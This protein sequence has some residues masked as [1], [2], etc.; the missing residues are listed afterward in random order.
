MSPKQAVRKTNGRKLSG[1]W[2]RRSALQFSASSLQASLTGRGP[3]GASLFQKSLPRWGALSARRLAVAGCGFCPI[4]WAS[5]G[6]EGPP[7][8]GPHPE[9]CA[10]SSPR[11]PV[12]SSPG[13]AGHPARGSGGP[14]QEPGARRP[15]SGRSPSLPQQKPWGH[16]CGCQP[17]RPLA[18]GPSVL[19]PALAAGACAPDLLTRGGRWRT[20]LRSSAQPLAAHRRRGW[21]TQ[22]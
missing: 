14:G 16:H 12:A 18:L 1:Y 11:V 10:P 21:G 9:T 15:T 3:G 20:L 4:C 19:P 8:S 2:P 6:T 17:G 22:G 5:E 13:R 7:S